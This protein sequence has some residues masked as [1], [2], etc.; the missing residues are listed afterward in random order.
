MGKGS[1]H[2]KK[3]PREGIVREEP[4]KGELSGSDDRLL[5]LSSKPRS[6]KRSPCLNAHRENNFKL[7]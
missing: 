4:V 2:S 1:G 5:L 3:S 6:T 7:F